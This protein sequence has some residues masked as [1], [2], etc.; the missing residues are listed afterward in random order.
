MSR[1]SKV[2]SSRSEATP[3]TQPA[4]T[5]AERPGRVL[6]TMIAILGVVIL[7][8]SARAFPEVMSLD[9]VPDF[10]VMFVTLHVEHMLKSTAASARLD[11]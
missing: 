11:P 8:L 7:D 2:A 5:S 1:T 4:T 9:S 10:I 3:W 6:P